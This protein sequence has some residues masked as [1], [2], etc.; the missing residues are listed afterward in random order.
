[1]GSLPLPGGFN[2]AAASNAAEIW[3]LQASMTYITGWASMRPRQV[4]PR[5]YLGEEAIRVGLAEL[6]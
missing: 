1:M 6:Q 3:P 2:E 5:R 4:M